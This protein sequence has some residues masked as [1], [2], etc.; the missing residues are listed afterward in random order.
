MSACNYVRLGCLA[1]AVVLD[2]GNAFTLAVAALLLVLSWILSI[3]PV[4]RVC[5]ILQAPLLSAG[6]PL[7]Q[8]ARP[9]VNALY[10]IRGRK[11]SN[12]NLTSIF[13]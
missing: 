1:A 2:W 3:V 13:D 8:F 11:L 9:L 4:R 10:R 12:S 7:Y 6:V 5:R